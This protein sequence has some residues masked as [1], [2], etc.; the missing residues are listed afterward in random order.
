[1]FLFSCFVNVFEQSYIVS[2]ITYT[3]NLH[4]VIWFQVFLSNAE[5]YIVP[6]SYCYLKIVNC[7]HTVILFP[8]TSTANK[9]YSHDLTDE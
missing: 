6:N 3:N 8:V 1:M 7:L 5:N 2:S 9:S 4:T